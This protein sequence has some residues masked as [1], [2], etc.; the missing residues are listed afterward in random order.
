MRVFFVTE[1][2]QARYSNSE[3][4]EMRSR[5]DCRAI[6]QRSESS[7]VIAEQKQS[8]HAITERS[9]IDQQAVGKRLQSNSKHIAEQKQRD[10]RGTAK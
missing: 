2:I 7:S 9:G 8:D 3:V 4:I 1:G 6:G 5:S 10:Y